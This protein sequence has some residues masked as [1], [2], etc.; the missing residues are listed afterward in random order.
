M[1]KTSLPFFTFFS[2]VFLLFFSSQLLHAQE[3]SVELGNTK[4]GLNQYFEITLKSQ[5]EPI[6][7]YSN[8]PDIRGFTKRGTSSSTST[9]F[10]NG[11]MSMSMGITQR[12]QARGKGTYQLRTFRMTVNGKQ[13][14]SKGASIKV[15]D[16]V[17]ASN[18]PFADFFGR[19]STPAKANDFIDVK[20][21]AFFAVTTDKNDIFVGEGV[22]LE[23]A[24]YIAMSNQAPLQFVEDI[25]T[26]LGEILKTVRP[27]NCWEEN[28]N[29]SEIVAERVMI[30]NKPYRKYKLYDGTFYPL[31]SEDITIPS[32][33]LKMIKYKVSKQTSFFGR[34]KKKDYKTFYSKAKTIKVKK[35]PPHPLKNKVSVGV[36]RLR[37]VIQKGDYETGKSFSY[38]FGIEGEGNISGIAEIQLPETYNFD[39]Y[40]PAVRENIKRSNGVVYGKKAFDYQIIPNEPGEYK[41]KDNFSWVYFDPQREVYDTLQSD[42]I[43][44]ITGES[45]RN[46]SISSTDFGVFYDMIPHQNNDLIPWATSIWQNAWVNVGILLL[47]LSLGYLVMKQ[48]EV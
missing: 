29:I 42:I 14:S 34:Q 36:Y 17:Q 40:P 27:E 26:E 24:F 37:E 4:I 48:R 20:D 39:F 3:V 35:L 44:N 28:F 13:V 22:H 6:K 47:L 12:Y 33:P 18:D 25:G 2:V 15:G 43:I 32:A 41:L 1:H 31:S 7:N 45:K 9:Q 11:Q 5:G 19:R 30:N 46:E 10:I 16:A 23:V 21:D 38:Y 8:F